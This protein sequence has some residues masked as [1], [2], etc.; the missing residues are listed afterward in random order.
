MLYNRVMFYYLLVTV[1]VLVCLFLLVAILLLP[2]IAAR[3][4]EFA[5]EMLALH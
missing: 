5:A 3:L 4:I 1:Y 2:W